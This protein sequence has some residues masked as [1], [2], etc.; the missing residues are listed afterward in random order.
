LEDGLTLE[1]CVE[2]GSRV[3]EL[4]GKNADRIE[5]CDNLAVGGTTVSYGVAENVIGRCHAE[6]AARVSPGEVPHR[7]RVMSMI[8]PRG[9]NF[10]YSPDE[11]SMMLRDI[12]VLRGLGTDG[13]VFGC[14]NPEDGLDKKTAAE[15]I[16][17][18]AGLDIT[19]HMA[20]DHI[21]ADEQIDALDWL[22]RSGVSRVLTHGSADPETPIL[23][24]RRRLL[25]YVEAA[26][27]QNE[28]RRIIILPG[29]GVTKDN[30]REL[31]AALGVREAHGTRIL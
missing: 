14:L 19:F 22:S 17:A 27:A 11:K 18:A 16:A 8:R 2:N 3:D 9:G 20:F 1:V 4:I 24:N 5:L 15:L 7:I 23:D 26:A 29:G 10:V 21:R 12:A 6:A 30:V 25:Q 31:C 13:V 28:N